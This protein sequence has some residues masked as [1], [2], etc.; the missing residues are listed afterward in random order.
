MAEG[1]TVVTDMARD[2]RTAGV[3]DQIMCTG[4]SWEPEKS[5]RLLEEVA[6]GLAC[7]GK[8]GGSELWSAG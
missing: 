2:R 7:R 3:G 4:K 8:T 5:C 6:G 1:N